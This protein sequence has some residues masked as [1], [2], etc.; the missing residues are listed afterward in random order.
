MIYGRGSEL[1]FGKLTTVDTDLELI[2]DDPKD[3]F[4]FPWIIGTTSSSPT[5]QKYLERRFEDA[6]ARLQRP[7]REENSIAEVVGS[8]NL[9]IAGL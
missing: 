8:R 2:D 1:Q 9:S 3:P 5:T 7:E 4:V 6:H